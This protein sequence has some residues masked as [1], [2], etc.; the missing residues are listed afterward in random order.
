MPRLEPDKV[1]SAGELAALKNLAAKHAGEEVGWIG[2][3]DARSLTERGLADRHGGGWKITPA[4]LAAH[5]ASKGEPHSAN[6]G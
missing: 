2:I 3:A 6:S 5:E 4:G 1:L